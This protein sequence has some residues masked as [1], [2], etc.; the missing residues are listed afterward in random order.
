MISNKPAGRLLYLD[1]VRALAALAVALFHYRGFVGQLAGK[2][3]PVIDFVVRHGYLGVNVFFVLSGFVIAHSL[4]KSRYSLTFLGR[5]VLRRQVRLAPPYWATVAIAAVWY[6]GNPDM[7][8]ARTSLATIAAHL[9]YVQDI[10]G[11][12]QLLDV[13]WTLCIEVQLYA[14]YVVFAW[15][16]QTDSPRW[17]VP[18]RDVVFGVT[19]LASLLMAW[20]PDDKLSV[21]LMPG[22][23]GPAAWFPYYWYMFALGVWV[24]WARDSRSARWWL[25]L[26]LLLAVAR[27]FEFHGAAP[28]VCTAT[29]C[30]LYLAASWQW[31][32]RMLGCRPL[33]YLGRISYSFYLLHVLIGGACLHWV[34]GHHAP[35]VWRDVAALC[36]ALVGSIVVAHALWWVVERPSIAWSRRI[37]PARQE[38]GDANMLDRCPVVDE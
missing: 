35:T 14:V 34:L 32:P 19:T 21:S 15:L 29:A 25:A 4:D 1:G 18:R 33:A 37:G 31:L 27:A 30:L 2:V 8:P 5:F 24:R 26:F 23:A 11:F 13:F 7:E 38:K 9:G 28:I 22:A 17:Q 6:A 3:P 12:P 36:V 20:V 10:L 16:A